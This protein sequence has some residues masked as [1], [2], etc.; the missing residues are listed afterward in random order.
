MAGATFFVVKTAAQY[1][2]RLPLQLAKHGVCAPF[3]CYLLVTACFRFC[4]K[5]IARPA[6]IPYKPS[7]DSLDANHLLQSLAASSSRSLVGAPPIVIALIVSF[8]FVHVGSRRKF[9]APEFVQ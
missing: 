2:V 4:A 5:E 3:W 1:T 8:R 6:L 9:G 7:H